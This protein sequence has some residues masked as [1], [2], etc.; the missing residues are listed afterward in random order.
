MMHKCWYCKKMH[1]PDLPIGSPNGIPDRCAW[2]TM[3]LKK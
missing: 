3:R 2:E 1:D